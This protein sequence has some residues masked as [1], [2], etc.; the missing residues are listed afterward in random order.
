MALPGQAVASPEQALAAL[1][2]P[3][4]G[5]VVALFSG[6]VLFHDS[7]PRAVED[8]STVP[9][10]RSSSEIWESYISL[11][12]ELRVLKAYRDMGEV[13]KILIFEDG[14][15]WLT[16]NGGRGWITIVDSCRQIERELAPLERRGR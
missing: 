7:A 6:P 8:R 4:A 10:T 3:L 15:K 5:Q 13:F 9:R 1:A 2:A 14:K 11:P 16:L 12:E